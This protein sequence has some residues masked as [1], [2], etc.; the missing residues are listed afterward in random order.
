MS[1]ETRGGGPGVFRSWDLEPVS[2]LAWNRGSRNEAPDTHL[3][4]RRSALRSSSQCLG[5]SR[6]LLSHR[7]RKVVT[8]ATPPPGSRLF[9]TRGGW[10]A[11]G[12]TEPPADRWFI[13]FSAKRKHEMAAYSKRHY[14]DHTWR[15]RN[16]HVIVEHI[17]GASSAAAV[18]NT[19]APDHPDPELHELPNVCAHFVVSPSGR[20][21]QL[22]HLTIRC[23]HTVGLNWT[24]I[25]VEHAG[26]RDA[27]LLGNRRELRASLHLTR[28]LR[29][30]FHIKVKNVI[31]HSESLRSPYHHELVRSLRNQTHGDMRHQLD[32]DLPPQVAQAEAVLNGFLRATGSSGSSRSRSRS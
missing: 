20:I 3:K 26:Y 1:Q 29:C 18:Y 25:G 17:A 14:G 24:A 2:E 16:P 30:R 6:A 4:S 11:N 23:R 7:L 28:Y 12:L 22:V 13:P 5:P 27:D 31:G 10:I 21:Y 9:P 15:L 8:S 32:A 19:F